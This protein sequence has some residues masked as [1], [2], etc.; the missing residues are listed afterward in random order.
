[1]TRA[2]HLQSTWFSIGELQLST[3]SNRVL[4]GSGV[5]V[6][7]SAANVQG[8]LLQQR[9]PS[10]TWRTVQHVTHPA[11][12]R[13]RLHANTAFRLV[14]PGTS[15]TSEAIDVAPR[16]RVEALSPRLIGGEVSPRPGIGRYLGPGERV[17]Y[18]TRRHS[19]VLGSAV[20]VW[21]I[22]FLTRGRTI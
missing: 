19:V 1:M 9:N 16:L 17:I 4:Y 6:A 7:A 12:L 10:G 18:S 14:V 15:G 5:T 3:S 20:V 8:A 11:Q 21:L 2:L 22:A 13:V